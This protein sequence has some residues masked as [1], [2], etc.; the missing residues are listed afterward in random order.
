[1]LTRIFMQGFP[2]EAILYRGGAHYLLDTFLTEFCVSLEKR[3][4]FYYFRISEV[5]G[6]P[7]AFIAL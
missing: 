3:P 1:M 5:W 4:C 2:S 6:L 7:I